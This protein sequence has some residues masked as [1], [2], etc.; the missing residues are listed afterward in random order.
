MQ[1]PVP[2]ASG[3]FRSSCRPP[4]F[5]CNLMDGG[6][7]GDENCRR[8]GEVLGRKSGKNPIILG[9]FWKSALESF[10]DSVESGKQGVLPAGLGRLSTISIENEIDEVA[11]MSEKF[12]E[13][14]DELGRRTNSGAIVSLGLLTTLIHE[15]GA[16]PQQEL[17]VRHVVSELT[18][19][20][21]AHKERLWVIGAA[22][23]Y[24]TYQKFLSRFPDAE[25][26]WDLHLLPITYRSSSSST[27]RFSTSR[28]SL[29]GSFIPFGGFFSM[30]SE[31]ET[32][33]S[34]PCPGS[35]CDLCN[36]KCAEE[37]EALLQ[38]G[39]STS[40]SD[41]CSTN[42]PSWLQM[43]KSDSHDALNV[44]KKDDRTTL[45]AKILELQNKWKKV[46]LS[47]HKHQPLVHLAIPQARPKVVA[48]DSF[49]VAADP[50]KCCSDGSS[51]SENKCPLMDASSTTDLHRIWHQEHDR[52]AQMSSQ[53]E[54][55]HVQNIS[56]IKQVTGIGGPLSSQKLPTY[57]LLPTHKAVPPSIT[58]VST[59]LGLRL[60]SLTSDRVPEKTS[61]GVPERWRVQGH[62]GCAQQLLGSA[63]SSSDPV[64]D[65]WL[66]TPLEVAQQSSPSSGHNHL[67]IYPDP[68]DFKAIW[69]SL[70]QEVGWQD[71]ALCIISQVVSCYK[72]GSLRRSRFGKDLWLTFLG[73][74]MAGKRR[75]ALALSEVFHHTKRLIYTDL[76]SQEWI[77]PPCTTCEFHELQA[78]EMMQRGKTVVD[79][80]A[81]ELR[82][83][84]HSVVYLENI[85]RADLLFQNCLSQALQTG[86]LKDTYGREFSTRNTIFVATST[87]IMDG[88][89]F[90]SNYSE[91]RVLRARR[92]QMQISVEC[93]A[94]E[95]G[96]CKDMAMVVT[97]AASVTKR[98]H[99]DMD[100]T[101]QLDRGTG[102]RRRPDKLSLDLN[103][104]VADVEEELDYVN[105]ETET[106][107]EDSV[108]WFNDFLRQVDRSVVFKPYDFNGAAHAFLEEMRDTLRSAVGFEVPLEIDDEAMV[109]IVAAGWLCR[110]QEA[111]KGWIRQVMRRGFLEAHQRHRLTADSVV[112]LA[113]CKGVALEQQAPGLCL[114]ASINLK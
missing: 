69:G 93:V 100:N 3:L 21:K 41:G 79:Y 18:A 105:R 64:L 80:I 62:K 14:S 89:V 74:D 56:E 26:D 96:S 8:I 102:T 60:T 72:S 2:T 83:K 67:E 40:V 58:T 30:P 114:P 84:P 109:Q 47:F 104:A 33:L 6:E 85:D 94:A 97:S 55:A 76:S 12:N 52:G 11:K 61:D 59:S 51:I 91:E 98:K 106:C 17:A 15:D 29:M 110:G 27:Q 103:L 87:M 77:R 20:L 10:L 43:T 44:S 73:P 90:T 99:N 78:C 86:K 101:S 35:P 36:K 22:E 1:P 63:S 45:N 37:V 71:E 57:N 70:K 42:L 81:D 50:R 25:K 13:L 112:K 108:A 54:P 111:I 31:F 92:W 24:E 7:D 39:S 46:C 5:L 82:Q 68:Q 34:S 53:A 107:T 32:P 16:G 28:S 48:M 65:A 49:D 113:S 88:E 75:T 4:I 19:L 66:K 9:M 38:D 23:N 95:G